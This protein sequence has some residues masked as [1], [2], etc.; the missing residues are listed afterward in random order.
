[1]E[2]GGDV[3]VFVVEGREGDV[4]SVEVDVVGEGILEHSGSSTR[5]GTCEAR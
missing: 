5:L 2:V 4:E 1:M 3:V